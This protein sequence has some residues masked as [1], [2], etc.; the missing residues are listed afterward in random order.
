[1]E[2]K[3]LFS[4]IERGLKIISR[5]IG[6]FNPQQQ[7]GEKKVWWNRT[8]LFISQ[9]AA[10]S[11]FRNP[12]HSRKSGGFNTLCLCFLHSWG[13]WSN[14]VISGRIEMFVVKLNFYCRNGKWYQPNCCDLLSVKPR[15]ARQVSECLGQL[16]TVGPSNRFC[17]SCF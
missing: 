15:D 14:V 4:K 13:T 16:F 9:A 3:I 2:F 7:P 10:R 11:E 1:M 12:P 6:Y 17:W 8:L 5:N